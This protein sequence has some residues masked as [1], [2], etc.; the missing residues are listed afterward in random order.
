MVEFKQIIS[1]RALL[2]FVYD[3]IVPINLS[4][5]SKEGIVRVISD[6][7][8]ISEE[9]LLTNYIFNHPE[10]SPIFKYISKLDP[11]YEREEKIDELAIELFITDNKKEVFSENIDTG[12]SRNIFEHIDYNKSKAKQADIINTFVRLINFFPKKEI[13][14]ADNIFSEYLSFVHSYNTGSIRKLKPLNE[15]TKE[16]IFIWNGRADKGEINLSSADYLENYKI[17]Q[18]LS[19]DIV[20][21]KKNSSVTEDIDRFSHKI[22]IV[23][24]PDRY[25][26]DKVKVDIDFSLFVLMKKIMNG[27]TP[28][29]LDRRKF[30]KFSEFIN[31]LSSFGKKNEELFVKNNSNDKF[32]LYK[33]EYGDFRFEEAR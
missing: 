26:Y 1:I 4:Y 5:R 12:E 32:R 19:P 30:I 13:A 15:M 20:P 7:N 21:E 29:I 2:N 10:L 33:D 16:V 28:N 22:P 18:K 9:N 24:K 6:R 31:N 14:P 17:S 8:Y 27:Y 3:I 23:F 25:T 11:A